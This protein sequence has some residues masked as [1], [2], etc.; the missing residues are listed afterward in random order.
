MSFCTDLNEDC[1]DD[2]AIL[3]TIPPHLPQFTPEHESEERMALTREDTI[4]GYADL[5]G[6]K[7]PGEE[8]DMER[9]LDAFETE[10]SRLPS[11]QKSAVHKGYTKYQACL[12]LR[13]ENYNAK[14]AAQR[15]TRYWAM[16]CSAYGE[17]TFSQEHTKDRTEEDYQ[18]V[19]KMASKAMKDPEVDAETRTWAKKFTN[20]YHKGHI[21]L[22]A[23]MVKTLPPGEAKGLTEA[24]KTRP[25]IAADEDFMLQF[26]R[27]E[28]FNAKHAAQR[29]AKYWDFR[30]HLLGRSD[31]FR[32]LTI[33]YLKENCPAELSSGIFVI[34]PA[35]AHG[36]GLLWR[37]ASREC[38][39]GLTDKGILKLIW[40]VYHAMLE[41]RSIR[42]NGLVL[43]NNQ[44]DV[45]SS[46]LRWSMF[47]E[48]IEF[49]LNCMPIRIR[50]G[51]DVSPP[52]GF[53][54]NLVAPVI[55]YLIGKKFRC[56][57]WIHTGTSEEIMSELEICGISR[58]QTPTEFGGTMDFDALAFGWIEERQSKGL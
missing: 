23:E 5:Y 56:R 35:D 22:L 40:Y 9:H 1:H 33:D 32:T 28:D 39:D 37:N 55:K 13:I 16:R 4:L 52:K 30:F 46:K 27:C 47:S 54:F 42:E 43:M 11:S 34:V 7:P 12:F 21:K 20:Q 25:D 26:L 8:L 45:L 31:A 49:A 17:E 29:M 41:E 14:S 48:Y 36:R 51:H 3:Q 50:A 6:Q 18:R 2:G 38:D 15:M 44:K 19:Y 58:D 24:L 10:L 57:Y 53:F